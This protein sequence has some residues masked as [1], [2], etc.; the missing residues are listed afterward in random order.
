VLIL[1]GGYFLLTTEPPKAIAEVIV[2]LAAALVIHDG[3]IAPATTV[4]GRLLSRG[5]SRLPRSAVLVIQCGFVVGAILTG[6]VL[7]ELV[8]QARPRHNPT[9]LVGD[10]AAGLAISWA[11][12]V[13]TLA[14]I[15]LVLVW[16]TRRSTGRPRST[17]G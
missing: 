5:G 10:Y 9:V 16:R 6:A 1:A 15:T 4:A 14:V 2:W 13:T 3:L 17:H 7:P 8:A 11:V 12:L